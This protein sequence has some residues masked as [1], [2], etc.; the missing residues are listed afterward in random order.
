MAWLSETRRLRALDVLSYS[1][2]IG[3]CETLARDWY[4]AVG[5]PERQVPC[6]SGWEGRWVW[7]K[8][9]PPGYGPRFGF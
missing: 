9:K 7:V 3:A 5:D 6:V 8:M 4:M 1:A 2:A